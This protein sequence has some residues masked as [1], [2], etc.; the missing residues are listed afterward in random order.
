VSLILALGALATLQRW[1]A[2]SW[3]RPGGGQNYRAPSRSS[4]SRSYSPPPR[5]S[6]SPSHNYSPGPSYPSSSGSY[7]RGPSVVYVPTSGSYSSGSS[8]GD[9]LGSALVVGFF[10]L[11]VILV[12]IWLRARGRQPERGTIAVDRGLQDQGLAALK[13]ND[14]GFDPAQFVERTK[15]VVA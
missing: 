8:I 11:A 3:A 5:S 7:N 2:S 1:P 6:P 10:I 14:P 9:G 4:P 12:I 15:S 13:S